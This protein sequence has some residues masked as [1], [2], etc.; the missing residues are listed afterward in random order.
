MPSPTTSSR[1]LMAE[2]RARQNRWDH[3]YVSAAREAAL[4]ATIAAENGDSV[5][6]WN[7]QNLR[8]QCLCLDGLFDEA[9]D[10]MQELVA[11]EVAIQQPLVE[12]QALN[13]LAVAFQGAGRLRDAIDAVNRA[14]ELVRGEDGDRVTWINAQCT[15]IAVNA[16]RGDLVSAW[17]ACGALIKDMD[18]DPPDEQLSAKA[19][20]AI[21]N[22]AFLRDDI[23]NGIEYHE[24][25]LI[26]FSPSKDLELWGKFNKGSAAMRLAAGIADA[27]TLRCIERA[28]ISAE[29]VGGSTEDHLLLAMTRA[30]WNYL[31]GEYGEAIELLKPVCEI[32]SSL[33]AQSAAEAFYLYG[34]ALFEVERRSEALTNLDRAV[35]EFDRADA[36]ERQHVVEEFIR[37]RF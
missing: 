32:S 5:S 7:M 26:R 19:Y 31:A 27:A 8:A 18:S 15:M 25:A 14:S 35:H 11:H 16:E 6:W 1:Y 23:E 10:V 21:G 9:I 3:D 2:L 20:W 29:I 22:V 28:E 12:G 37:S 30:H 33:A 34:R 24:R 4:A 17:Q 36:H 13:T